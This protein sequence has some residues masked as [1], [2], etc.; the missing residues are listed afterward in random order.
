MR[1]SIAT[2][3]LLLAAPALGC[4]ATPPAVADG[5]GSNPGK[6]RFASIAR[7]SPPPVCPGASCADNALGPP[8]GKIV[9][10]GACA[11]LDLAFTGGTIT[12]TKPADLALHLGGAVAGLTRV[13][14]S[15]DAMSYTVIGFVAP[16]ASDLPAGASATC[17]ASVAGQV[18]TLSLGSC[19][20]LA[21][22]SF[23]RLTRD[24]SNPGRLL[25]DAAEALSFAPLS[26]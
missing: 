9:D 20:S 19:N 14:A 7:C 5:Q 15:R 16:R 23:L 8:D 6:D 25:I 4:E 10:L 3:A 22:A 26:P 17:A 11:T 1:P 13:E 12:A 21:Q 18:A 2:V 24:A